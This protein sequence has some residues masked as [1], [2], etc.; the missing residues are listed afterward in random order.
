M[1]LKT[2]DPA[3]GPGTKHTRNPAAPFTASPNA[4][5]IGKL[6]H[7]RRPFSRNRRMSPASIR[8]TIGRAF[9]RHIGKSTM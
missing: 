2:K 4:W 7:F 9:F 1:T 8:T 6:Y 5:S 3:L